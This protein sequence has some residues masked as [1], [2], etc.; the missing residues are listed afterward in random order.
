MLRFL[1]K[2]FSGFFL[3]NEHL[4]KHVTYRIGGPAD[5]FVYPK[6]IES[7]IALLGECKNLNLDYF[8]LGGGANLLVHDDGF[9]GVV[10]SVSKYFNEINQEG[11]LVKVDAGVSLKDLIVFCEMA[12]LG[13]LEYLSGIPGTVGGALIMNAGTHKAEVGE[14]VKDVQLLDSNFNTI[15]ILAKDIDF[16]YR[17]TPQLKDKI[18]LSCTIQLQEASPQQLK[19]ARINQ[20][21][22]RSAK[23]PLEFP[24][25]G[26]VF[27]RPPQNYVGAMVQEL[28][29]KGKSHG[30]AMI[31]EK[32]GG[33]IINLGCAKASDVLFLIDDIKKEVETHYNIM[34]EEEVKFVGF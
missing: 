6:N 33:F 23:Q 7:L 20:L 2:S 8:F 31:S 18:L 30:D 34:L 24:S 16:K 29:L 22:T 21:K 26:S 10:I 17:S 15:N 27:K 4:A 13:G 11:N 19:E 32:H 28:G 25:C 14:C 3:I 5:F 1:E 12:G 9:R